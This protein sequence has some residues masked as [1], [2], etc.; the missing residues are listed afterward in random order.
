MRSSDREGKGGRGGAPARG[1]VGIT[2]V[3]STTTETTVSRVHAHGVSPLAR[4]LR[5]SL[6]LSSFT[7]TGVRGLCRCQAWPTGAGDAWHRAMTL[8]LL[9]RA[10]LARAPLAR[11]R[12]PLARDRAPLARDL[13]AP[14][15]RPRN[16][17]NPRRATS[18]RAEP[19]DRSSFAGTR[20]RGCPA[21]G[22]QGAN[23]SGSWTA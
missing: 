11:D 6:R 17:P 3:G 1:I 16:A 21:R 10:P 20:R 14:P 23:L 8:C 18:R 19:A 4:R 15:T 13:L 9:V 12:A 2:T 5:L 22:E 7:C